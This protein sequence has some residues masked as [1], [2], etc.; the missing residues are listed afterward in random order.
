MHTILVTG[1]EGLVGKAACAAL[2]ERGHAV[3]KLDLAASQP[4]GCGDIRDLERLRD[5]V[6]ACDGI[7]HLAAVSRVSWGEQDPDGCW[8]TNVVG[9]E[10]VMRAAAAAAARP[11]VILASSR[12]VYGEPDRLPV[13][14]DA[15]VRPVNVYGRSKAAAERVALDWCDRGLNTAIVRFAS[16]YGSV[17]D[18]PDRVVPAFARS[19]AA[20][21]TLRV[22]GR[23][24]VFD[25]THLDDTVAGLLALIDVVATGERLPPV[26]L[27]TG[28]PTSL[29]ELADIANK[30]GGS[31]AKV[32]EAT[33]PVYNVSRFVGEPIRARELLGW[34]AKVN[35][36]EG[37]SQLVGEFQAQLQPDTTAAPCVA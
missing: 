23:D 33:S 30:A 5:H 27:V 22:C 35:I 20:G 19:A 26:H 8:Q 31:R 17:T 7:L 4:T 1:A 24:H 3:A 36:V 28:Q 6:D 15:P 18:H 9:T 16:V 13:T 2:A 25:F 29:G 12:E 11:W 37:V 32:L 21:G 14:E 10:N 34:R